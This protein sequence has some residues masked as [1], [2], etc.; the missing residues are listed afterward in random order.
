LELFPEAYQNSFCSASRRCLLIIINVEI[1]IGVDRSTLFRLCD[2]VFNPQKDH[3]EK[4]VKGGQKQ[5]EVRQI[6]MPNPS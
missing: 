6:E 5:E 3:R 1:D 2:G 4:I